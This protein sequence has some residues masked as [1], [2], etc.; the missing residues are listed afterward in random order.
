M[1]IDDT[2]HNE[3][4]KFSQRNPNGVIHRCFLKELK[5]LKS[6]HISKSISFKKIGQNKSKKVVCKGLHYRK[7]HI[8][9]NISNFGVYVFQGYE[10]FSADPFFKFCD[11]K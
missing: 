9:D 7:I 10:N 1:I 3:L 11:Q 6:K 2:L 5:D 8:F 4:V